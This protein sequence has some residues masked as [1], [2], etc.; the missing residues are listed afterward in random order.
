MIFFKYHQVNLMFVYECQIETMENLLFVSSQFGN[1]Y[2]TFGLIGNTALPYALHL[3]PESYV[4][5]LKARH[6]EHFKELTKNAIYITPATFIGNIKYKVE[7]F[8]CL[9]DSYQILWR[10]I[11]KGESSDESDDEEEDEEKET[12][13]ETK[14]KGGRGTNHPDE[15]WFKVISRGN[16][17]I[18]YIMCL[19]ALEL[20]QYIRVGKWLSKCKLSMKEMK[21]RIETC[22][23]VTPLILRAED[24]PKEIDIYKCNQIP[25]QHGMYL[26]NCELEGELVHL[27]SEILGD[28]YIP[29]K[30]AFYVAES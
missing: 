15:G 7:R 24:I 10:P 27:Q 16:I 1:E 29:A 20:P 12:K 23:S 3:V 4:G 25:I 14:Q 18:F 9:P 13:K 22:R 21:N 6:R 30:S 2:H 11:K 8:N 5:Y 17:A 26:Q 19:K 28:V